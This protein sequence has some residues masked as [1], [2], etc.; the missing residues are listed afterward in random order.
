MSRFCRSI[1]PHRL[2][3]I[4]IAI[5][6]SLFLAATA[7][8]AKTVYWGRTKKTVV[9]DPG[10]GGTDSG[11]R[12]PDGTLEKQVALDLARLIADELADPSRTHLTRTDDYRLDT[13]RRTD[14]ANN[15]KADAFVS[16][17]A[18]GSFSPTPGGIHIYCYK[19]TTTE[20]PSSANRAPAPFDTWDR[21]QLKHARSSRLLARHL[22]ER[23]DPLLDVEIS[24]APVLVLQGAD[25]PAVLIEVGYLSN[26][27]EAKALRSATHREALARAVA[28]AI[29][30]FFEEL[31]QAK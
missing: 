19:G 16:L 12:S 13:E 14:M 23:L 30:A 28:A 15:L 8:D 27:E 29:K 26:P 31:R 7:A 2:L 20:R 21:I 17:H 6:T 18:G 24:D 5:S 25:M 9:L 4:A 22:K 3:M 11:A 10:H 1:G